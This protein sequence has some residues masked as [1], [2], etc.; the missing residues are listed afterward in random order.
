MC[1]RFCSS[2]PC[3]MSVGPSI[4]TPRP[5]RPGA[6]FSANSWFRMNW[7]IAD[8]DA[9]PYSF[10]QAGAI[11]PSFVNAER[12]FSNAGR[13]SGL[14]SYGLLPAISFGSSSFRNVR[15]LD[16]QAACAGES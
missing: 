10:G 3:E 11:H 4:I 5:P 1:W 6:R 12:H 14:A 13:S 7:S 8:I 16:R 15:T 2:L 9:P